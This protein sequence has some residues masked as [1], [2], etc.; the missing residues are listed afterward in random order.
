[1]TSRK[2]LSDT[3]GQSHS[4]PTHRPPA[5]L[6]R[7]FLMNVW[8]NPAGPPRRLV[9]AAGLLRA[10]LRQFAVAGAWLGAAL[11]ALDPVEDRSVS[12]P[13]RWLA[14]AVGSAKQ[15]GH[16]AQGLLHQSSCR[17]GPCSKTSGQIQP[18]FRK[19]CSRKV[20][21]IPRTSKPAT[22]S[23][24]VP[25]VGSREPPEWAVVL[26]SGGQSERNKTRSRFHGRG[27]RG[28]L[29]DPGG[30]RGPPRGRP[31]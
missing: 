20:S 28:F 19:T 13:L 16:H 30:A 24:R 10:V 26:V 4:A 18:I 6:P 14:V 21:R 22:V 1:M 27:V 29:P 23:C 5:S 17:H 8:E 15:Q 31:R 2:N 7:E 11:F 9:P 25:V 3:L 12:L